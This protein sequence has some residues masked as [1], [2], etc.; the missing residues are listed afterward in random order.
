VALVNNAQREHLEFMAT[1]EAVAREN[2]SVIDGTARRRRGRVPADDEFT[3]CGRVAGPRACLTFCDRRRA[4]RHP[5]GTGIA[6]TQGHGAWQVDVQ[7]P[8][9]P[10]ALRCICRAPQRAQR[11]G[12]HRL[13]AGRRRAAGAITR[14]LEAF[15]P[16]KGRSRAFSV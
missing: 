12:R 1:V 7:T 2:G 14:G 5:F 13:R 9:G 15:E 6:W 3:P 4:R 10:L 16:V 11:A 8:A